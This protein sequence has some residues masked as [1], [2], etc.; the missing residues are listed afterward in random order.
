MKFLTNFK[1]QLGHYFRHFNFLES[2]IEHA[3]RKNEFV[4]YY[5]PEID[6][7]TGQVLGVEA[8]M[9]WIHPEKGL[10]P[11]MEFIPLLEKTG[12]INKLTPF[13]FEQT[14]K[15]LHFLHN[16]GYPDLFMSVNLSCRQLQDKSLLNVIKKNLKKYKINP[17][18]YECELT[19]STSMS[20]LPDD[21]LVLQNIDKLK[22][23]LSLDD[24]GTGYTSFHYLKNLNVH[25]MKIDREFIATI[26]DNER[27]E[28]ILKSIIDLGHKLNLQ[29]VAEGIETKEQEKWLKKHKCNLGQGFYFA[30]PMPLIDLLTFLYKNKQNSK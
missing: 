24:F 19:E 30:R 28:V 25:K 20:N 9:R 12:L 8:L 3:I 1:K 26:F 17:T 15:D 13:L 5:Q 29:V 4:F 16:N 22:L 7:K 6:L 11:P 21:L 27:N 18:Q 2:D 14:M 10:I 23:R